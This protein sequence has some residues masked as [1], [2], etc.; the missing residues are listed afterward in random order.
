MITGTILNVVNLISYIKK[1]LNV[2]NDHYQRMLRVITF[3]QQYKIC[4]N[5]VVMTIHMHLCK[6]IYKM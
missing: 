2:L 5:H 1:E 3:S 6:S 4:G